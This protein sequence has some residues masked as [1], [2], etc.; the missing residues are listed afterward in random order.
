MKLFF[1][2]RVIP[3]E[4]EPKRNKHYFTTQKMQIRSPVQ[5]LFEETRTLGDAALC[6]TTLLG[7]AFSL[8]LHMLFFPSV[9][10]KIDVAKHINTHFEIFSAFLGLVLA[11]LLFSINHLSHARQSEHTFFPSSSPK[12]SGL[13]VRSTT[14]KLVSFI[15]K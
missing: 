1:L 13:E 4:L 3:D 12:A 7:S 10:L 2:G 11:A 14:V 6:A 8:Q 15:N 9:M 5:Y